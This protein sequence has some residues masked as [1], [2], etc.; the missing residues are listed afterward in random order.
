MDDD[1]MLYSETAKKL[2]HEYAKDMPIIDYHCHLS[3]KQIW[4]NKKFKN[5][6]EAWIYGDNYG[7]H[8]KWRF[9]RSN[10]V[11]EEF[12]TGN[13]SD[14]DKF[15][16][17]AR[18]VPYTLGNPL[19][20]WTHMELR[21]Y[22]G[23]NELLNEET[24]DAIWE[25]ANAELA[26]EELRVKGIFKKFKVKLVCT[27]DDPTDSLEYHIKI[28]ESGEFDTKVIPA[29]RPDKGLNINNPTFKDWISKLAEVS[30]ISINTY[31][32]FMNAMENRINFFHSQG[33]RLSDHA[34]DYVPYAEA[35]YDEVNEIFQR[36]LKG[37][38][39]NFDDETKYRTYTLQFLGKQYAK[40]GWVMQYHIN[41]MRNVNTVMLEKIGP[42]SGF[43]SIN[44]VNIAYPL[45][46]LMDS[47]EKENA[48]PKTILY[49]LNPKD[50]YTLAT[51]IGNFQT[52][53]IP[54][55]I[56][57]GSAWW[58]NDQKDGMLEQMKA[59]ANCGQLSRFVGMLTDSRS[60]L[61][62]PRHEY[63]RR[64]LCNMIGEWV[65]NGEYPNDIKFLGKIVQDICYN[66]A[67]EYFGMP[68]D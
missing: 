43:D 31:E 6:T 59:L 20:N 4:D 52:G 14:Y 13:A 18:T 22:F 24:A 25:K 47:L 33:S 5:I 11:S 65:E 37:E 34:L 48:L 42:D 56:Q 8:Y 64:L 39:V 49:T 23:I 61:S 35:S 2:F 29:M 46:R 16:A 60:F 9:M 19:Y 63:F 41:A 7:D 12:L 67:K 62:Y 58:F 50:N 32:D 3:P 17:W 44:D 30:G 45:A 66:N 26:K 54:G 55:K 53:G 15:K 21:R 10:G 68:V 27:T 51:I 1:F 28:R 57:F 38:K 36:A 40:N